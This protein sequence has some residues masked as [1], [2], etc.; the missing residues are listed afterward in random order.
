[1]ATQLSFTELLKLLPSCPGPGTLA[2]QGSD[3]SWPVYIP[4]GLPA[5]IPPHL[6]HLVS[7]AS[8]P[9]HP[10]V[11]VLSAPGAV[12]KTTLARE[13]AHAKNA[14]LWDLS[15]RS[16][17]RDALAGALGKAFGYA[18]LGTVLGQL[19]AGRLFVVI[20]ALDE[21]RL[22]GEDPFMDFLD[23]IGKVAISAPGAVFVLLGRTQTAEETWLALTDLGVRVHLHR[24]DFFNETQRIEYLDRRLEQRQETARSIGAHRAEFEEARGLIFS[25]IQ[26]AIAP[27]GEEKE[28]AEAVAFLGYAPVLDAIAVLFED[29]QNYHG[30]IGTLH[31]EERR[32]VANGRPGRVYV[33]RTVVETILDREQNEKVLKNLRPELAGQAPPTW[34]EW[35]KLYAPA[36][37]RA[38][39]L[40]RILGD[41]RPPVVD[42]PPAIRQR[43][44]EHIQSF[45]NE[46]PFLREAKSAANI[47]FEAY[48]FA[49]ALV[50]PAHPLREQVAERVQR[51]DAVPSRLLADFYFF[52]RTVANRP[53]PLTHVGLLYGSLLSG[54]TESRRLRIDLQAGEPEPDEWNKKNPSV[55]F[56]WIDPTA[57]EPEEADLGS[58]T[59][60]LTVGVADRLIFRRP[61]KDASIIL[62]S[63]IRIE[64]AVSELVIGPDVQIRAN[65]LELS[66]P[67][68]LIVKGSPSRPG[69]TGGD[70]LVVLEAL[71]SA[72]VSS[73]NKVTCYGA[74]AVNW[75]GC[76]AY[77]WTPYTAE[78]AQAVKSDPRL[79]LVYRRFRRIVTA[80]RSHKKGDLA[81]LQDKIR[82]ERMLQ[83]ALGE[84]LLARLLEDRLLY[85][86]GKFYF[87]DREVASNLVGVSWQDLRR[88]LTPPKLIGYLQRFAD[89]HR[90]LLRPA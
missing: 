40:A 63:I 44:E 47:V 77:P 89:A 36:E 85:T 62:P 37:Q 34:N 64:T 61:L 67:E 56:E 78:A 60:P 12:G 42:A 22:K 84:A 50:D 31:E 24:I 87:L 13:I 86:K 43:Y 80:F 79:A 82:H 68:T 59:A 7:E 6:T 81:R 52:F 5:F 3:P 69:D 83:G 10:Q 49:D 15:K 75:P 17:S 45:F 23:D 25:Q 90:E 46:H 53:I 72:A 66:K 74:L 71:S 70:Q 39:L 26:K 18:Q 2:I 88:G 28:S 14:P 65:T 33:L 27:P 9:G 8:L 55:D 4:N 30:L 20:D 54:E 73:V 51:Q 21:V 32:A 41:P 29:E 1:V 38:R 76:R 57:D 35:Q 19:A 48:L 11:I 58:I 16:V